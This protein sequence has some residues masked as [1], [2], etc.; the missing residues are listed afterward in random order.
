MVE[1]IY[2]RYQICFNL[3]FEDKEATRVATF[4]I[5]R[6]VYFRSLIRMENFFKIS[7]SNWNTIRSGG[8]GVILREG[9]GRICRTTGE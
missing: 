3:R 9:L 7:F 4:N 1:S 8:P 2:I 6:I 5:H